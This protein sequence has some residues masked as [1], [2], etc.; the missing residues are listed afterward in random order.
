MHRV[1]HAIDPY[2][3]KRY[4]Q[5][6]Q[7]KPGHK[8]CIDCEQE[9]P[10]DAFHKMQGGYRPTCK[11]CRKAHESRPIV[12]VQLP[13]FVVSKVCTKCDK[14]KD[15]EEFNKM[16][17]GKGDRHSQCRQCVSEYNHQ[18]RIDHPEEHRTRDQAKNARPEYKAGRMRRH[19]ERTVSDPHYLELQRQH[20]QRH[21]QKH[22]DEARNYSTL[23]RMHVS[24]GDK[25][26]YERLLERDG[27]HCYICNKT[28]LPEHKIDFDHVIPLARGG[29]HVESNIRPTHRACNRRKRNKLL[30][31]L[32]PHDRR[33][34]Y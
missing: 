12:I 18:F 1:Y 28:I 19:R 10:F 23:R 27:M 2:Q 21:H 22:P 33:G 7:A 15:I 32:T 6:P 26:S 31:E 17:D 13:L 4:K 29:P 9:K 3:P 24:T 20:R 34:I 30:S 5:F 11:V 14:E 16:K 25:V 8:F